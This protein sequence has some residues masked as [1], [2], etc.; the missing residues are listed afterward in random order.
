MTANV[1]LG[2]RKWVMK[3]CCTRSSFLKI[4]QYSVVD[5]I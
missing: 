3:M 1:L 2:K 5:D 4:F